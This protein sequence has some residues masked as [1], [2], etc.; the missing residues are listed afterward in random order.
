MYI[1]Y[2]ITNASRLQIFVSFQSANCISLPASVIIII[3]SAQYVYRRPFCFIIAKSIVKQLLDYYS[4]T[5]NVVVC[6]VYVKLCNPLLSPLYRYLMYRLKLQKSL[7]A[8][9]NIHKYE[10]YIFSMLL[11]S[12]HFDIQLFFFLFHHTSRPSLKIL[13]FTNGVFFTNVR[14]LLFSTLNVQLKGAEVTDLYLETS[15]VV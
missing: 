6:C 15:E 3:L 9:S 11:Q 5:D 14:L 13:V 7:L 1:K 4:Q 12:K 10:T 8:L 2:G